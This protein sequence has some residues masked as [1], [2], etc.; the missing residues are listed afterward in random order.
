MKGASAFVGVA[1]LATVVGVVAVSATSGSAAEQADVPP[2][3]VEDYSYPGA[4]VVLAEHGLKLFK[5]DGHIVFDSARPYTGSQC[6]TGLIQV[7]KHL[8]VE[9]YGVYYCFR[10]IG[11]KGYL[12]LE[13]PGTFGVRGGSETILVKA[14]LPDNTVLPTYEVAPNQPVAIEPGNDGDTPQAILVELRNE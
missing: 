3:I 5:G 13:V 9:P 1:V 11:S 6:A 2:S 14:K 7:E 12:T 8:D 10:T 4:E